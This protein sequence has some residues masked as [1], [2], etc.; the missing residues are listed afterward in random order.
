MAAR[1][2]RIHAEVVAQ[3]VREEGRRDARCKK[4]LCG[5]GIVQDAELQEPSDGDLV[6]GNVNIVPEYIFTQH[7]RAL[8][9][10]LEHEVVDGQAVRGEFAVDRVRPRDI[11]C[12]AVI[13]ATGIEEEVER[14]GSHG[15]VV[16]HV[17]QRRSV[18]ARCYDRRVSLVA[19]AIS[20][21][22]LEEESLEFPFVFRV[23]DGFHDGTMGDAGDDIGL[24][25]QG[26][27]EIVFDDTALLDCFFQ[28]GEVFR[29]GGG[30]G[31][32]RRDLLL[33]GVYGGKRAKDFVD[34]V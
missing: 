12:V 25:Y 26:Y 32:V 21:T 10:H 18:G 7:V 29:G 27:F 34:L 33:N 17:M 4:I 24:A 3:T 23:L 1:I 5:V 2:V 14:A 6:R 31:D 13:L 15:L 16:V 19:A 8:L 9:L 11:R 30:E 28:Q 20:D 22:A